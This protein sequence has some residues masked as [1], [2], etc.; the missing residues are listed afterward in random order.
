MINYVF[1]AILVTKE[2]TSRCDAPWKR[3]K[4]REICFC[5]NRSVCCNRIDAFDDFESFSEK[6]LKFI[7]KHMKLWTSADLTTL[8]WTHFLLFALPFA[9]LCCI[10]GFARSG[11]FSPFAKEVS[12]RRERQ[13]ET[14]D[15]WK[16]E[17]ITLLINWPSCSLLF[18]SLSVARFSRFAPLS[19]L[20]FFSSIFSLRQIVNFFKS[21]SS[22]YSCARKLDGPSSNAFVHT[23]K[24][25]TLMEQEEEISASFSEFPSILIFMIM[26]M[27][28]S[29][30]S[31]KCTKIIN[32]M[33]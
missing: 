3:I 11:R 16:R 8:Y 12:G 28:F 33:S 22:S 15:G 14:N 9:I 1:N 24:T 2:E 27:S 29:C 32:V 5:P 21:F 19:V 26:S 6:S 13:N 18:L 17:L 23:N 4:S 30:D 7:H 25:S 20:R 10:L 31:W